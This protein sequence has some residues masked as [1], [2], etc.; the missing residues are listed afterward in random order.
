MKVAAAF[1]VAAIGF[2]SAAM[3]VDEIHK[4]PIQGGLD[5]GQHTKQ[6]INPDIKLF[7]GNQ[8]TPAVEKKIGEWDSNRKTMR[9]SLQERCDTAFVSSILALQDRARRE[10]GNAV[11]NIT[12][13][14]M[15]GKTDSATEYAC[16]SG[17]ASAGVHLRGTVVKLK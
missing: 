8:K 6:T 17:R 4:M 1:A 16:T 13:E 11:I 12:S 5:A 15:E 14:S 3:A 2:S 9:K 10:G 7:F